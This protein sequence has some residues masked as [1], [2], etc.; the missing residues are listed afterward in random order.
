MAKM[1]LELAEE[2]IR[3][4]KEKAVEMKVSMFIAVVDEMGKLVAFA[5]MGE[6]GIGFGEKISVAKAKT[7]VAYKRT[8]KDTMDRYANYPGNYFI[9]AMAGLYPNEFWAGPGGVP[10]IVDGELV[11]GLGVSGSTPENDHKCATEALA[12]FQKK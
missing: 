3:K 8:T 10:I 11:G 9:T 7:A 6:T 2:C 4:A 12:S 5:R 1:T